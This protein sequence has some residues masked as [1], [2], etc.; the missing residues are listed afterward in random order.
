[1]RRHLGGALRGAALGLV[2]GALWFTIEAVAGWAAGSFLP[3]GVIQKLAL[4]D[5]GLGA[6]AGLLVGLALPGLRGGAL[7]LGIAAFYGLLRVYAPPGYGAEAV[8][9][10]AAVA[11][12]AAGIRLLG[13]GAGGLLGFVHVSLLATA[14][15][16]IL[17]IGSQEVR[18]ALRGMRLPL[19]VAAVPVLAVLVDRLLAF[20][21]RSRAARLGVELT[22]GLVAAFVLGRPL[23][24]TPLEQTLVTAVPPPAGTPD[25]FLV[26]FDTTRA[27]HLSLYGYERETSPRLTEFAKDA[28]VFTQARSTA[29]WTLPGHA[30]ML[31]G[32]Y[33]NKHGA[34]LAGGWLGGQSIDGRRNVA[35]PLKPDKTTVTE[36]LRD[37]GYSTGAFIA[38]FSYLY[39]DFGLSQGFQ[40]YD[41]A[42][43]LLLRFEPAAI[44]F[45]RRFAPGFCL[46]PFRSARQ[47]N[48]AAL[49]WLDVA[50]KGRPA[51]M[52]LNYME[53]HQPWLA[54]APHD[55]WV[56]GLPEAHELAQ[57][58]LYTHEVKDFTAD[59]I[60]FITANYDGQVAAMDEA[61]AEL[62][63]ALR[64]R[65]RL[66]NALIIVTSDHGELLGDHGQVGHMGR[67]LYEGLLHI[68]MIVRFPGADRPMGTTDRHVQNL[69]VTPTVLE[70]AGVPVPEDVQGRDVRTV[71]R[72]SFAEEDINPFLVAE[73]GEFYDR[74]TRVL[75]EGSWK[76]ITTSRGEKKLFD[77][78]RD[79]GETRDLGAEE[80]DRLAAMSRRLEA[81]MPTRVAAANPDQQVN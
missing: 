37:R 57:R 2:A 8:Y 79:P 17:E 38:N 80:P 32:L 25:V 49:E 30:S 33:P 66:D 15:L 76:L 36:L 44:R 18:A 48:A 43:G 46:K 9:V 40:H 1:M 68:P 6:A 42:P 65:G 67:M 23:T 31:T 20:G 64:A 28:L 75:F 81:A 21:L 62:I 4:L 14:A 55:K 10:V 24:T 11:A 34:H 26:S 69:D 41:D 56:W 59:E 39:R 78:A 61:F 50:P 13:S 27:D 51:F 60:G 72:P 52:F 22:A 35:Y 47:I 45:A 5:L 54:P 7:A 19:V 71:E 63:E 29:G 12:C 77:L 53:P 70:I 74:A 73:Y 16:V 58:N 3:A